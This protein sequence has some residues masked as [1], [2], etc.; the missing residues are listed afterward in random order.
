M[1]IS[2]RIDNIK[3]RFNVI[4]VVNCDLYTPSSIDLYNQIQK[5]HQDVY[6]TLDRIVFVIT[7]DYYKQNSPA[8]MMLQSLQTMINNIDISNFFVFVVTTNPNST[9]EYQWVLDNISTDKVPVIIHECEGEY[10]REDGST[11]FKYVK[12]QNIEN[13]FIVD[14]LSDKHKHLLFESKS[15]CMAPWTSLMLDQT[16]DVKLCCESTEKIGDC[17]QNSLE[18]IWNSSSIKQLRKDM[19]A[20]K[21]IQSCNLCYTLEELGR[22]STRKSLNRKFLNQAD[23]IDL[24]QP[25]GSLIDYSLNYLD[26]RFNNLCN[27]SCRSCG[28]GSSSSWYKPALAIGRIDKSTKALKIAGK[29]DR[30]IF[31]QLMEQIDNLEK[32][33]FAGGEPLMMEDFYQI[34]DELDRRG[35]H[36]VELVYNINMTKSSL[37]GRS[38]FDLWKNFKKISIG[39]SL[40]GEYQRGE[41][42]RCGQ[43]WNDVVEFR[44]EMLAQRPDIDF[45]IS[46]TTSIINALHIPDFHK[47]WVEQ[48]LIK[49]EDFNI[50][51]LFWPDYLRADSAPKYLKDSIKEKYH[52]HL[53]WLR[54]KDPV[55]RATYGFESMINLIEGGKDFDPIDFWNNITPLDQYY[56]VNL[57]EVF[58]ELSDLPRS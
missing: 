37:L 29:H 5:L 23:K 3:S 41:Y 15:F 45:Y 49:P 14:S 9:T 40:D 53:E 51:I 10:S 30:D 33:Y 55:G 38:I 52:K 39:A 16:S 32:I 42:L 7:K 12:Y 17:S 11:E 6:E 2:Q 13:S 35:R 21:K 22:D 57:L 19:L 50:N 8:G 43:H 1:N 31:N 44:K 28:L 25:D 58:P 27:L 4:D 46:A 48:G 56:G 20:G 18:Q 36:D 54:P 26:A 34:V 47:S 24:T